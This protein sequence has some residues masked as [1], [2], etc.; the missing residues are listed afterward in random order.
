MTWLI[1]RLTASTHCRAHRSE[2]YFLPTFSSNIAFLRRS[3]LLDPK[4]DVLLDMLSKPTQ[5]VMNSN[6][7]KVKAVYFKCGYEGELGDTGVVMPVL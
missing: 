6:F 5:G 3:V 4:H 2:P 1:R 7:R